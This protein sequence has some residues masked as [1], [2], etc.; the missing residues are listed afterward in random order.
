MRKTVTIV[1]AAALFGILAAVVMAQGGG[2]T[3]TTATTSTTEATETTETTETETTPDVTTPEPTITTEDTV[4]DI[5]GPCDEAEHANDARCTGAG[6]ADDRGGDDD[7]HGGDNSGPG[8][9]NSGRGG[10]GDD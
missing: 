5:S 6:L 2:D 1:L 3:S 10:G 7:R 8:S 9:A 4:E